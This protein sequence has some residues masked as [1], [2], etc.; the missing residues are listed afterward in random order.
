MAGLNLTG[1]AYGYASAGVAT[2]LPP[3]YAGSNA[4]ATISSRAYG[5]GSMGPNSGPRTAAYGTTVAGVAG[6]ML[7]LYL[8]WSLPR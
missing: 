5:V 6:A 4:G 1:R 2:G 3:S 8:W 7:L